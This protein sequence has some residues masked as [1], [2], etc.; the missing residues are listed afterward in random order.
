MQANKFAVVFLVLYAWANCLPA[1]AADSPPVEDGNLLLE[2]CVAA[3]KGIDGDASVDMMKA[4]YCMGYLSGFM[5]AHS[6]TVFENHRMVK[7]S[8]AQFAFCT[9]Q[10]KITNAQLVRIVVKF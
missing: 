1:C 6:A 5:A 8:N 2:D 3:Q 10:R 4:N 7:Q 9:D